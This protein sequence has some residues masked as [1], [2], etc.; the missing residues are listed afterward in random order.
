MAISKIFVKSLAVASILIETYPAGIYLFNS[1]N[2]RLGH[3]TKSDNNK[4]TRTTLLMT[5]FW[6]FKREQILHYSF[7]SI[8][9]LEEVNAS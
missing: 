3:C 9:D 7:V 2:Y 5:L 8:V 1:T 4:H 6:C